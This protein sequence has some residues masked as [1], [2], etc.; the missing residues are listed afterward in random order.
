MNKMIKKQ[1]HHHQVNFE[2]SKNL[3]IDV[4][5]EQIDSPANLGSIFRNAEAFGV[6]TIWINNSNKKDLESTRFKRT[7]RSTW[8]NLKI[9]FY[10]N[11]Q[12]VFK[13]SKG[14]KV[15]LEITSNSRNIYKLGKIET[16]QI[17]LVLGNEKS[18]IAEDILEELDEVYHINMFGKNSSLNVSQSLGIALH[19]VRR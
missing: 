12:S 15:G 5:L 1:L 19:E 10:E 9:E 3:Q 6:E 4:F 17:L 16:D 2:K 14:L 7:S 8:R 18:G 13:Y 11:Y